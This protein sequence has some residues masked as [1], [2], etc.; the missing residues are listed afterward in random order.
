MPLMI[1]RTR[2]GKLGAFKNFNLFPMILIKSHLDVFNLESSF[3]RAHFIEKATEAPN[4]AL[5]IIRS[6]FTEL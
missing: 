4:V 6:A 1:L 2:A 3:K 5:V